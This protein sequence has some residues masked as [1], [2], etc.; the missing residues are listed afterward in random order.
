MLKL[1]TRLERTRNFVL[2]IFSIVMVA[3]L[4]FFYT[5]ASNNVQANLA[6]SDET[7]ATVSGNAI[8]VGELVRQKENYAQFSR[9]QSFPSRMILDGII[10][11]RISRVE[12]ERLGLTASDAEVA[13]SIR[14]QFKTEDG[15]PFDQ[16]LYEQNITEQFGS[17]STYEQSVRDDLSARKLEAFLTAGVVVSEEE[18][19]ND[20]Q[21]KNTKFDLN[22]VAVNTADLAKTITPTDA[23]LQEYFEKNKANY[24]I[25]TPQKKIKYVF[26]NTNKIGEKLQIPEADL[27]AEFENLPADKKSAGVLGQEI[28]LRVA[29]PEFDSQVQTKAA[30]LVQRLKADGTTVSEEAFAELAK[31][32]SEN[33]STAPNGGKLPG[34]VKENLQKADDPYQ[35]L[36]KMKPGE[37]T[38]PISYQNR[39]FILR[40]GD[41][42]PKTF[43]MAR[44]ELEVSL[45]N[46]R[47]YTV[48]AELAQKVADSLKQTKDPAKTA[49]EFAGQANMN[50]AEMVRET[51]Y[52]KPGDDIPNIG[53]SPQF[54]EGI[55]LLVNANDVGD[56]TPIQNGFAI[57]MLV[58]KKEPRDATLDEV[59]S[60]IA[61]TLKN[62]KARTQV[63]EI[64]RQIASGATSASGLGAA[65]SSKGMTV[66]EQKDFVLGSPLGEGP[67]AGT[68]DALQDLIYGMKVGDVSKEP[69]KVG[70]NWYIVGVTNRE[71]A[72]SADFAT[73]RTS[74]MEQMLARKRAK[75][76]GDYLSATRL[77]ME[78]DGSIKVYKEV[79]EKV[80]A[81]V[82]GEAPAG[83]PQG[84]PQGIVP[85]PAG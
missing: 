19:L 35:R 48:A 72:N 29:K 79:L 34:P 74:L 85:P 15:K 58:D 9:G 84:L 77:R 12:A 64:A 65:A 50:A 75:V 11:S 17:I 40:R 60:Q 36:L 18:V 54:E 16:A 31:G 4:V 13:A 43:E 30:E 25:N 45:R 44:K 83:L 52:V 1:F 71:E 69:I 59:K 42:V 61:E 78:G 10:G 41:D 7:V 20:Y 68:S 67:T 76:F 5:P 38:E 82:P 49:Q 32:H 53:V 46:R 80:D 51:G 81:P 21:R 14:E 37:V 26:V 66:K 3:S 24:Y 70:D 27:R 63:E 55:S 2:L 57:P 28:V 22:Y 6:Q 23:E 62:E 73:Q 56:K 39:Y 8:S 47:A 33:P